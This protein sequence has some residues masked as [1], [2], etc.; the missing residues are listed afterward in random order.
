MA[1]SNEVQYIRYYTP[2]S[3][4]EKVE[5]PRLPKKQ[6]RPKAAPAPKKTA[7]VVRVDGLAAIG[8]AVAAVM[9]LCMLMGCAQVYSLNRQIQDLEVYV[10]QLELR[11]ESLEADYAH[12]YDLEEIRQAA[13]SMGLVPKDQVE[14][15]TV[16]IPEME[17][18]VEIS[19][20]ENLLNTIR[21]F[22]A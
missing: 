21:E 5:L 4:A 15:V 7:P 8:I 2:G 1:R 10:S 19:W 17:T 18:V 22:F 9:L 16:H 14:H 20:W 6:P 11:Q 12:G 13:L 3:A